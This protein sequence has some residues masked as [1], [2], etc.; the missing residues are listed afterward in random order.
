MRL[1]LV[2]RRRASCLCHCTIG[3]GVRPKQETSYFSSLIGTILVSKIPSRVF[4]YSIFLDRLFGCPPYQS[5][6]RQPFGGQD[7]NSFVV[8]TLLIPL[9][10]VIPPIEVP[11]GAFGTGMMMLTFTGSLIENLICDLYDFRKLC[12]MLTTLYRTTR[13]REIWTSIGVRP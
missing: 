3:V 8:V 6:A 13:G 4:I 2:Y 11:A 5:I 10:S 7:V 1:Y 12:K 9:V